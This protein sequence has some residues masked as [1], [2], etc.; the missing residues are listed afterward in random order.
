MCNPTATTKIFSHD[1]TNILL[2][3]CQRMSKC[4]RSVSSTTIDTIEKMRLAY[5]Q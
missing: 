4:N 5:A 1:I 3:V 2:L